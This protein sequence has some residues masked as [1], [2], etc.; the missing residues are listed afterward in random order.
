MNKLGGTLIRENAPMIYGLKGWCE[1]VSVEASRVIPYPEITVDLS[2]R[3][4]GVALR[5]KYS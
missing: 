4:Y 2:A 1:Q 3:N 5:R